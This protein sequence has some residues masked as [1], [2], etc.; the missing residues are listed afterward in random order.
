MHSKSLVITA[1][2]GIVF[3]LLFFLVSVVI[4]LVIRLFFFRE[5]A[6]K[7]KEEMQTQVWHHRSR[8]LSLV[9][10]IFGAVVL[11]LGWTVLT[12]MKLKSSV[13]AAVA[14]Y[15]GYRYWRS[16]RG[17]A[18]VSQWLM[19]GDITQRSDPSNS[20]VESDARKDGARG[21]P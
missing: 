19:E 1:R 15:L 18:S 8:I 14:F 4:G 21:S 13:V 10:M 7:E 11:G 5:Y 2:N 17:A 6:E 12:D 9:A 16:P 20:T 3:G